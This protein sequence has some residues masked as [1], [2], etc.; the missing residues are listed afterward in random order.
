MK[1][2]KSNPSSPDAIQKINQSL[3]QKQPLWREVLGKQY[4]HT[5]FTT[6]HD[7]YLYKV[8]DPF[9]EEIYHFISK[10]EFDEI[11]KANEE[12]NLVR[13]SGR[14]LSETGYIDYETDNRG[15]FRY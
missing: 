15:Y 10:E 7:Q 13:S 2:Q 6:E 12:N 11:D 5:R 8:Q 4:L 14:S 1:H 9:S 3:Q